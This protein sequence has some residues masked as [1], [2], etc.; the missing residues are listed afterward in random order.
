VIAAFGADLRHPDGSLDRHRLRE[1]A[2]GTPERRRALEAILH[3][4][5]LAR[6]EELCRHAGGPYQ[7]LVIPLLVESG[8][9]N[10]VDRVLVVD[11]PEE[12]QRARLMARDG[13]T[14]AGVDRLLAAQVDR[15]SRLRGAD[16]VLV[17]AGSRDELRQQAALLHANYLQRAASRNKGG[18]KG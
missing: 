11:C 13:E 18:M 16:D 9:A 6:M 14:P 7:L 5:I 8:L 12:L 3:P 1:L 2:F 10:R 4:R 15:A 17:N